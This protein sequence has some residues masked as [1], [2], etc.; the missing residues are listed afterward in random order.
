VEVGKVL[1]ATYA[2]GL[3]MGYRWYQAQGKT[4]L[5]PFGFGLSYTTFE[6]AG[7]STTSTQIDETR[8]V[9]ISVEVRN[10]G[11]RA[12]ADVV[13]VY[14]TFADTYGEPPKRLVG[15]EKVFLYPGERRR[16]SIELDPASAHHPFSYWNSKTHNWELMAGRVALD[17][18]RSSAQVETRIDV[19]VRRP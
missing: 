13:Q 12:G 8:P 3:Q 7:A 4:P 2:E 17:V 9:T 6:Y 1:T 11:S 18:S 10:T 14:A 19:D 16:V 5:F 15:F